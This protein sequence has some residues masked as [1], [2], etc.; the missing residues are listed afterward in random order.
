MKAKNRKTKKRRAGLTRAAPVKGKRRCKEC[1]FWK[2]GPFHVFGAHH[3]TQV[4]G[5]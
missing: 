2:R 3:K 4:R 1:G 5:S